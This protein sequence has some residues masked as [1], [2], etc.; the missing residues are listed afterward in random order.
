MHEKGWQSEQRIVKKTQKTVLFPPAPY[1]S[2]RLPPLSLNHTSSIL[3]SLFSNSL[4]LSYLL[5]VA[6]TPFSTLLSV[7]HLSL[8]DSYLVFSLL[9]FSLSYT[10]LSVS[11]LATLS[12]LLHSHF[13]YTLISTKLSFLPL[14]RWVPLFS[15]SLI[16]VSILVFLF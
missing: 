6:P 1:L 3:L 8:S 4:S 9:S 13:Y 11:Y 14:Y 5:S 16:Y 15:P 7:F 10:P 12:F 2:R